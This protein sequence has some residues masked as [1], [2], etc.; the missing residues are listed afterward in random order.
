MLQFKIIFKCKGM[1]NI[2]NHYVNF[3]LKALFFLTTFLLFFPKSNYFYP[4]YAVIVC[5][6]FAVLI[7]IHGL[8]K[9]NSLK[10]ILNNLN[11]IDWLFVFDFFFNFIAISYSHQ[12]RA[13]IEE[14]IYQYSY[15]L[16]YLAV[17]SATILEPSSMSKIFTM[18]HLQLLM[19]TTKILYTVL[20]KFQFISVDGRISYNAMHP[21]LLASYMLI[22]LCIIVY[23]TC[24][25]IGN[26][27]ITL[28]HLISFAM[29]SFT[30]VMTSS[31]GGMLGL[32]LGLAMIFLI[33]N[34]KTAKKIKFITI[35]SILL[36]FGIYFVFPIHFQ[37][38]TGLLN[39]ENYMTMGSRLHIWTFAVKQFLLNPFLGIGPAVC[40]FDIQQF[41]H[42]SMV[43]AHNFLLEKLCNGGIIGTIFY[44]APILFLIY[45]KLKSDEPSYIKFLLCFLITA[46]F[47]NSFFSP[48]F[49]LPI[50]SINLFIIFGA[51][52]SLKFD[53]HETK[54][55]NSTGRY[56]IFYEIFV[57]TIFSYAFSLILKMILL[58]FPTDVCNELT[59]WIFPLSF[60]LSCFI[61]E[62]YINK[63]AQPET[64][65][66]D[67]GASFNVKNYAI[68]GLVLVTSSGFLLYSGFYFYAA[69]KAN[70]IAIDKVLNFSANM[71][72]KY[73]DIAMKN[74]PTNIA[75]MTNKS[76][77]VFIDEFFKNAA[78][79]NN[80]NLKQCVKMTEKCMA[81]FPQDQLLKSNYVL[82]LSKLNGISDFK[83]I[84][85]KKIKPLADSVEASRTSI[86]H[87]II[88]Q[89]P[90]SA[91]AKFADV[92]KADACN[93]WIAS[94]DILKKEALNI[95]MQEKTLGPDTKLSKY[96]D[97]IA[98][99][100]K[101]AVNMEL[102]NIDKFL[103]NGVNAAFV[104]T[105]KAEKF[106]PVKGF[107]EYSLQSKQQNEII[108]TV[109][110]ILPLIWKYSKN[111]DSA[112]AAAE[113]NKMFGNDVLFP[114]IDYFVFNNPS[115]AGKLGR[116]DTQLN[117]YL[118]VLKLFS[119]KKYDEAV[120]VMEPALKSFPSSIEMNSILLSWIYFK[121]NKCDV[122]KEIV[123]FSQ[124][125]LLIPYKRDFAYKRDMLFGGNMM[126]FYYLP[127]QAYYNEFILL[128]LL[129]MNNGDYKA[130]IKDVFDY[131]NAVV[132]NN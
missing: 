49:I 65:I 47:T 16:I 113:Y 44:L 60:L 45:K 82:L 19:F 99:T 87:E 77:V 114:I 18:L 127:I 76:F 121:L 58:P 12:P 84:T 80:E 93:R 52:N 51:I 83:N 104:A 46:L 7:F 117:S 11:L 103:I 10:L 91:F 105:E 90:H 26:K 4:N 64:A 108:S 97:Y 118:T 14:V 29:V 27:K 101:L 9:T 2:I 38:I 20:Y 95:I 61:Y 122:A 43:D 56:D 37:R 100:L 131:L 125:K 132:Y 28:F 85:F 3:L 62:F 35:S 1:R 78:L 106:L 67:D 31:R 126:H 22:G 72:K 86:D 6:T 110:L 21:N 66:I 34:I 32:F 48:H 59:F 107:K 17:R 8:I 111:Y 112:T 33:S 63:N 115:A 55:L 96:F 79:K 40:N 15:L 50:L 68:A 89:N 120:A 23:H 54:A 30:L 123:L 41:S 69:E 109:S 88:L 42:S 119:E 36:A 98:I 5:I 39:S 53:D 74:D 25:S 24:K 128:G 81:I 129:K 124:F 13:S 92:F 94:S 73:L 116:Y 70:I 75:Y 102:P 57:I 71:S 130:V